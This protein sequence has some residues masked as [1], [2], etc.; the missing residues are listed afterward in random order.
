MDSIHQTPGRIEFAD[1]LTAF[2][3][4]TLALMG[5][6]PLYAPYD[7]LL[8]LS[9][10]EGITPLPWFPLVISLGALSVSL[11]FLGAALFGMDQRVVIEAA[12]GEVIH[13]YRIA[14]IG[15]RTTRHPFAAIGGTNIAVHEWS[16]GPATYNI[17]MELPGKG[18]IEF[19]RFTEREDA[20]R[21]LAEVRNLIGR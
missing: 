19:G 12:T 8:R 2:H 6:L 3:R 9:W 4:I 21:Y 14:V 16:D 15:T 20:E 5:L 1:R 18:L 7:L 17:A 10:P 11:L 13:T